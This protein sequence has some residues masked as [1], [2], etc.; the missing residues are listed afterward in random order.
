MCEITEL[1]QETVTFN[2]KVIRQDVIEVTFKVNQNTARTFSK[3]Q[4]DLCIEGKENLAKIAEYIAEN[5]QENLTQFYEKIGF[6]KT[7]NYDFDISTKGIEIKVI[8]HDDRKAIV[9]K[10]RG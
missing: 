4:Q 9:K 5:F 8:D 2:C 3:I 7:D 6:I 1:K 10:V